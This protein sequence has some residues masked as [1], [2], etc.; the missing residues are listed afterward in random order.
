M[1]EERFSFLPNVV[2]VCRPSFDE[3]NCSLNSNDNE[4]LTLK[5]IPSHLLIDLHVD[6]L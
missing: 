3:D 6:F 5:M 2:G 1:K 4:E